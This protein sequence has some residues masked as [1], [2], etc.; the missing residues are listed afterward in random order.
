ML[1]IW[2][3][4]PGYSVKLLNFPKHFAKFLSSES[5]CSYSK[6]KFSRLLNKVHYQTTS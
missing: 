2:V 1:D 6:L 5:L 3:N 4:L